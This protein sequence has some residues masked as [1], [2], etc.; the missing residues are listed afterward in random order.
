MEVRP[1]LHLLEGRSGAKLGRLAPELI[2]GDPELP[3]VVVE[4]G[5]EPVGHPAGPHVW[6]EVGGQGAQE[7]VELRGCHG[8]DLGDSSKL[9]GFSHA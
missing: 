8:E 4:P 5:A 1:D 2:G 9:L 3:T 7:R 6:S